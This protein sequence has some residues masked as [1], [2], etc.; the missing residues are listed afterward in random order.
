MANTCSGY[1]S[2]APQDVLDAIKDHIRKDKKN[3]GPRWANRRNLEEPTACLIWDLCES[4]GDTAVRCGADE[5][6]MK[7][8]GKKVPLTRPPTP[9]G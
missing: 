5:C 9:I 4:E 1:D 8:G 2:T 6:C 7:D 3:G